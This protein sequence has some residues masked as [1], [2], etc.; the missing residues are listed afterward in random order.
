MSDTTDSVED[1]GPR[2]R[3]PDDVPEELEEEWMEELKSGFVP[4]ELQHP[5]GKRA[6]RDSG[7]TVMEQTSSE[8][9]EGDERV[10]FTWS[11]EDDSE[12]VVMDCGQEGTLIG[13]RYN[14]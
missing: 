6:M 13:V 14:G 8:L 1:G 9:K 4:G 10:V 7:V 12:L 5:E 2:S 11:G 3:V